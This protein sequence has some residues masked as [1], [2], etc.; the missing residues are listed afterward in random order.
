[1]QRAPSCAIASGP[2]SPNVRAESICTRDARDANL[3]LVAG[4]WREREQRED[5]NDERL[6]MKALRR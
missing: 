4:D 3:S 5:Q 1:M 2:S 6:V